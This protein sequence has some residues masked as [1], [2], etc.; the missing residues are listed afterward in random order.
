M[1]S[2]TPGFVRLSQPIEKTLITIAPLA[3]CLLS[4]QTAS[5]TR[6][7]LQILLRLLQRNPAP[8]GVV[9]SYLAK[10]GFAQGAAHEKFDD[11][12]W[13]G[14]DLPHDWAVE[15]PFDS[16]GSNSHGSKAIGKNFP[17]KSIGWYR[18]SFE[19]P[20]SDKGR[21]IA[22]DFDGVFRDSQ[23]WVNGFYLGRESSGYNSFGYDVSDY[24]NYGGGNTIAVRVDASLE[25]GWFYEGAG[26]YRH[27]WLTKTA[28]LHVARSGTFVTTQV[29]GRQANVTVHTT[30]Q[31]DADAPARFDIEQSVVDPK[32]RP[33]A[34]WSSRP[35]S[36]GPGGQTDVPAALRIGDA[37]L[38][39][40]ETP[41]LSSRRCVRAGGKST[42]TKLRSASAPSA[43]MPRRGSSS[44][45]SGSSSR[46]F[47]TIKTTRGWGLP[48]PTPWKPGA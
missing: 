45:V 5:L 35:L 12:K 32:G 4:S 15:L 30:L 13:R 28:P 43:G 39:S 33:V 46:G 2:R 1:P 9:F 17:E 34:R 20:A 10:A 37:Q 26:I 14:L 6:E 18:K 3:L 41:T 42:G 8:P 11:S 21:R 25:E 27:V 19:I 24:L 36:L 22:I 29:K 23:V 7:R 47:A 48:C 16:R 44:T 40:V 31:N 38:W